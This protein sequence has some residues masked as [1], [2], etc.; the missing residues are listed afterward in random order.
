MMKT[1]GSPH[2][3][4]VLQEVRRSA[5]LYVCKDFRNVH[6]ERIWKL[7]SGGCPCKALDGDSSSLGARG[8]NTGSLKRLQYVFLLQP[9]VQ[10]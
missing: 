9:T 3:Y 8:E 6:Q 2:I 1:G 7:G 10:A 5:M 4:R